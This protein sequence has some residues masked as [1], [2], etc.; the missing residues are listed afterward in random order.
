[1]ATLE[2]ALQQA[3]AS[4]EA[5]RPDIA[6]NVYRAILAKFPQNAEARDGL[7]SL[8]G[9]QGETLDETGIPNQQDIQ[10]VLT[11]YNSGKLAD[12]EVRANALIAQFPKALILRNILGAALLDQGKHQGA[13]ECFRDAL[14]LEPNAAESHNNL[15]IALQAYGASEDAVASFRE[16]VRLK[17]DYPDAHNNLGVA[18]NDL[19]QIESAIASYQDALSY[20]PDYAEA[21]NNLGAA[22]SELGDY[23][24]A[25]TFYR[26]ALQ[27]NPNYAEAH[28]NL[29]NAL[30]SFKQRDEAIACFRQALEINPNYAEAHNNLGNALLDLGRL[31]EA[32]QSYERALEA[33]PDLPETLNNLGNV[34]REL[35]RFDQS[36][37]CFNKLLSIH[38]DNAEVLNNL[39]VAYKDLGDI[40]K[41]ISSYRQALVLK[42]NFA[43]AHINLGGALLGE[44]NLDEA[45][46]SYRAADP[47]TESAKISALLLEC[48]FR[49]NDKIAFD[50]QLQL[51]KSK[52]ETFNFRA[53]AA[54]A[55]AAHQFD[56]ANKYQFCE[57]PTALVTE[58]NLFEDGI[59]DESAVASLAQEIHDSGGNERFAPGHISSGYKSVGNIF[60]KNNARFD[61]LEQTLRQY[62]Q[63]FFELH[64]GDQ[65]HFIQNWPQDFAL[66]GWYIRLLK[67]GEITAHIHTAWVSGVLYLKVPDKKGG[68]EGNIEFTLRGYELPV[69]R[70]DYPRK[71]V[72]TQ[73]GSLALFPSSLPHRVV[74][75]TSDE[76]RICIPFDVIPK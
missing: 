44:G 22:L 69:L 70:D 8:M 60:T 65:S 35:D 39:G 53:A 28:N 30:Q 36:I 11:L 3:T 38:P 41:A 27:H 56:T 7:H 32:L 37:E 2:E 12:A 47:Q 43:D 52:Q 57:D 75:F 62:I 61:K 1:M 67:G 42:P 50:I 45:I 59:L 20:A 4:V 6:V 23:E 34:Y 15:G 48:Y 13:V 64:K 71:M 26:Q 72:Q 49:K 51:I 63:K 5:G 40:G 9:S 46:A 76:E 24:Q 17:I 18:L 10:A 16:A 73:S 58:F 31:E 29:G 66:D 21:H 74:P 33:K 19:G 54:A 55:F 68:D 25:I 14:A